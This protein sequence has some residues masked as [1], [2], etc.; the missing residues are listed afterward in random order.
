MDVAKLVAA[1]WN[2]SQSLEDVAGP[3]RVAGRDTRLVQI[4]TTA[5]T[6]SEAGIRSLITDPVKGSKIAVESPY[7]IAD[8]AVL[9][10]E[11]TYSV[12]SAVTAATGW[13]PWP[14][15]WKPSP[16]ARPIR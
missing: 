11:L 4:A 8:F 14:I 10:P 7:L 12:P 13:M 15:A 16:T 9:D 3:N 5:G 1:L 6:G 2:S